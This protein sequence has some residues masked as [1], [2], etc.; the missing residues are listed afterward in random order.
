MHPV[1][2]EETTFGLPARDDDDASGS[3]R[4]TLYIRR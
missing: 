1:A 2:C 3:G 4:D